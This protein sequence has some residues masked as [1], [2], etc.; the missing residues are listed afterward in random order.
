M[1]ARKRFVVAA[2]ALPLLTG[3]AACGQV[4]EVQQGLQN[5]DEQ[6]QQAQQNL[7]SISACAQAINVASFMPNF[8][9]PQQAKADA[10]AKA[11]ELRKLADQTADQTLR[12]NLLEVEQ[13]VQRV[14][15]GEITL[16]ASAEWTTA[17]LERYQQV[18]TTCSQ[19]GN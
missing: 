9:N 2:L 10:E 16:E 4:Q 1:R 19:I 12:Q 7:D 11:E 15:S 13:S 14:A 5:A 8:A 17:Q 3:L 6:I 18:T